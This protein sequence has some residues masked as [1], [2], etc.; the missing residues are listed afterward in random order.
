MIVVK[1]EVKWTVGVYQRIVS[2]NQT[3][4]KKEKTKEKNTDDI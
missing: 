2:I 1:N 3:N 4:H